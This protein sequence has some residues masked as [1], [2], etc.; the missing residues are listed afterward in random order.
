M[1]ILL[2]MISEDK[3]GFSYTHP[4]LKLLYVWEYTCNLF[5]FINI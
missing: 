4:T 2:M 3:K 5:K 1:S